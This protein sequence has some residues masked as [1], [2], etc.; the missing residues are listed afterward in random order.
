LT[1]RDL[2]VLTNEQEV[3]VEA[4]P[5]SRLLVIAP[6]G[7]GKTEV[8]AHRLLRLRDGGYVSAP[9]QVLVLSFS[10]AAVGEL[11]RRTRQDGALLTGI[12]V[13][14]LDS[15]ATRLLAIHEPD[16]DWHAEGYLERIR[17][18]TKLVAEDEEFR[19]EVGAYRHLVLD[20]VQDFVGDRAEFVDE[21]VRALT[22][23]AGFTILG[24]PAQGVFDFQLE[25]SRSTLTSL[26]FLRRLL[27]GTPK[28]EV[29]NL[30]VN[31]RSRSRATTRIASLG[32]V[33]RDRALGLDVSGDGGIGSELLGLHPY[34]LSQATAILEGIRRDKGTGAVLCRYNSQA[35]VVSRELRERGVHHRLNGPASDAWV[36]PWVGL[37][38][39]GYQFPT[40]SYASFA[41]RHSELRDAKPEVDMAWRALKR[42]EGL[43]GRDLSLRT[44]VSR[45]RT[46]RIPDD[47]AESDPQ[48][49]IV[50]SVH[51]AKG[52]EWD[53]VFLCGI[54]IDEDD[55]FESLRVAYV[56]M[57]RAREELF[58][59]VD[60]DTRGMRSKDQRDSRWLRTDPRSHMMSQ[61]QIVAGDVE[62]NVPA[63]SFLVDADPA[64]IQDY[65]ATSLRAGDE[66]AL[67]LERSFVEGKPRAVYRIE[68]ETTVIGITTQGLSD[69]L[70][71]A[72][73]RAGGG[74]F[75]GMLSG[76]RVQAVETV[77]GSSAAGSRAGLGNAGLWLRP[78]L[79]GLANAMWG[80][81]P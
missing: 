68:H 79:E 33:L 26:Q 40:I 15:Y 62:S 70:S 80:R 20:E 66:V 75:P 37:L 3:I 59:L 72:V 34:G 11:K 23:D 52:L 43:P 46:R 18:A 74:P 53:V 35:L 48:W 17:R 65:L 55:E 8:V 7:C 61:I 77:G 25:G 24:D 4:P 36:G 76:A 57:T 47:L 22:D 51:R 9:S 2:L 19:Q 39:R 1:P 50:S 60:P 63:G 21:I 38:F 27:D 41:A 16:G 58:A 73:Q 13:S 30:T 64:A 42:A 5:G 49:L 12:P 69:A 31:F 54:E 28:P 14:T 32:G 78:R 71:D 44:L 45:T 6:A 56:A 29:R 10:N 81:V 67:T